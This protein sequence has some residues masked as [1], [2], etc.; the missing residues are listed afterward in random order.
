MKFWLFMLVM[1]LVIPLMMIGF[2]NYF[3]KKAPKQINTVF[4]Y[5]TSMSMKNR[6]TWEFAHHYC[7]K[8]WYACGW[9]LLLISV[10][11]MVFLLGRSKDCIET[12]GEILTI[13]QLVVLVG[14]IFPTERAL[15]KEFDKNGKR[16]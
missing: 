6:D 12:V 9:A 14:S 4:G 1:E 7:G 16:R 13:I 10:L 5:R 3:K 15:R 2:G 11:V 8:I